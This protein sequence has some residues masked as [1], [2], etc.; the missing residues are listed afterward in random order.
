MPPKP[1]RWQIAPRVASLVI[2]R[3]PQRHPLLVQVLYNRGITTPEQAD[4]F[5]A[6]DALIGN[7][8]QMYGMNQAVERLRRAIR[9]GEAIA[10]YGDFDVDGVTATVLLVQ[11][12]Q[13]IGAQ[14]KP[15]IPHRIDEGYGLNVDALTQL[16]EQGVQVVVTVDC[17][18]R[19]L[20]EVAFGKKIGLDMIV[21][22][23]HAPGDELPDS[24]ATINPKQSLCKYPFKEL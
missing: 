7:P 1:K 14:V 9:A 8:F 12:L 10:V 16:K 20:D 17:G 22:D 21:T 4:A 6:P 19:S 23:H 11:A 18:V 13:S 15:Y 24:F 3:F 5:L 2:A